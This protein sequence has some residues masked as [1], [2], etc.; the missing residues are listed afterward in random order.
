MSKQKELKEQII[1]LRNKMHIIIESKNDLLDYEVLSIS[2][3]LDH[4]LNEYYDVLSHIK[5]IKNIKKSSLEK[6][7]R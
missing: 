4:L 3:Q 5:N 1:E 7:N 2:Q 6:F